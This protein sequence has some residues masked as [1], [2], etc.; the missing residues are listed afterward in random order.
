MPPMRLP[1]TLRNCYAW[2]LAAAFFSCFAAAPRVSA[3]DVIDRIAARIEG[4]IIL[5]SDVRQLGRYQM[6]VEGKSENDAQLLDRLI[7]QWVVQNEADAEV[8]CFAATLRGT[9]EA[10]RTER[11]SSAGQNRDA[12][13]SDQLSRFAIPAIHTNRRHGH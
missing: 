5:L 11:H 1:R 7:D 9:Q 2:I 12:T 6:L 3:Q 8:F 13:L 4:D 10:K